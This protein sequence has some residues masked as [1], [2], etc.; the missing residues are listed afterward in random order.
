VLSFNLVLAEIVHE[1][2]PIVDIAWG[3]C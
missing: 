1:A 2:D 3:N